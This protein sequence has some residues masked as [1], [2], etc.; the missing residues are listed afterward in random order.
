MYVNISYMAMMRN[1]DWLESIQRILVTTLQSKKLHIGEK[2]R[3]YTIA[4]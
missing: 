1:V 4:R 3:D 2:E